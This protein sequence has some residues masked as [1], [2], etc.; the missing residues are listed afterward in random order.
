MPVT[1][2]AGGH[3]H[4]NRAGKKLWGTD[5]PPVQL[6]PAAWQEI[7]ITISFP[8]FAKDIAY[9]FNLFTTPGP[10]FETTTM[11]GMSVVKILPQETTL[12]DIV[13]GTVPAG[14]NYV[15]WR[16]VLNWTKQPSYTRFGPAFSPIRPGYQTDLRGGSG[17]IE[18]SG[19]WRRRIHIGLSGTS[20]VL[21]RKQ[22]TRNTNEQPGWSPGNATHYPSGGP[23][24]GWTWGVQQEGVLAHFI[25]KRAGGNNVWRGGSNSASLV[26]P[27]D[28]SSIWT[29]ALLVKPGRQNASI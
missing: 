22:S 1:P 8:D 23:R 5:E 19:V 17:L 27:T 29:G 2:G 21:S 18:I 25:D 26:D 20:I 15:D 28:Y 13:I 7:P 10:P 4:V 24:P 11:Y 14:I 6:I 3:I 9:G 12:P 16:V